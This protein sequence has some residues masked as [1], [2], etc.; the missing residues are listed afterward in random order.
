MVYKF[1]TLQVK[2]TTQ[3][4]LNIC[5][6]VGK[7]S[8][9]DRKVLN[10]LYPACSSARPT[11][12]QKRKFDPT[13]ES[14]AEAKRAKKKAAIPGGGKPRKV[15]IVLLESPIAVVPKGGA[16]KLLKA[17]GRIIQTKIRRSMSPL[18]I[19]RVISNGFPT[20]HGASAATFMESGRDNSLSVISDQALSGDAVA[21]LAGNGSVYLAEMGA[22]VVN[23]LVVALHSFDACADK[24]QTCTYM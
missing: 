14:I 24:L 2:D 20:F 16:R 4:A 21:N 1:L 9:A 13:E 22:K 7:P 15:T 17:Q 3:R 6:R 10:T 5:K 18:E 19:R 8:Q 23:L 11:F 12:P